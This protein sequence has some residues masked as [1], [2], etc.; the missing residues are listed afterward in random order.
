MERIEAKS[1]QEDFHTKFARDKHNF[2]HGGGYGINAY[3]GNNHGSVNFTPERHNGVAHTDRL[4]PNRTYCLTLCQR[5]SCLTECQSW[6]R[7]NR[8]TLGFTGVCNSS[9]SASLLSSDSD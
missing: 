2:Y 9:S 5:I 7:S 3:G 1:K 8:L 4:L 6:N